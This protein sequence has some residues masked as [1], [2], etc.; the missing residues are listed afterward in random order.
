MINK[1]A[2][3]GEYLKITRICSGYSQN[4]VANLA[5]LEPSTVKRIEDGTSTPSPKTLLALADALDL[6]VSVLAKFI[7]SYRQLIHAGLPDLADYLNIKY[8]MA[9]RDIADL[10]RHAQ[11]LGYDPR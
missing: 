8:K 2:T 7:D 11:Q 9:K 6:P 4:R 1:A 3:L 5:G 10:K